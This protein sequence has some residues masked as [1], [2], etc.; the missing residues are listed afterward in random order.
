M[1]L[2]SACHI[3]E[4]FVGGSWARKVRLPVGHPTDDPWPHFGT[5]R[6]RCG[7]QGT[8]LPCAE[9]PG[10]VLQGARLSLGLCACRVVVQD[11]GGGSWLY[12]IPSGLRGPQHGA[13]PWPWPDPGEQEV[14]S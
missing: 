8:S 14:S 5:C 6:R 7:L 11:F 13:W 2:P 4:L 3:L 10:F 9:S 1:W 12:L